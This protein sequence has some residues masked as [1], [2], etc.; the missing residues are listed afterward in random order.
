MR[1]RTLVTIGKPIEED[2][3]HICISNELERF[4]I[5]CQHVEWSTPCYGKELHTDKIKELIS[6]LQ[7]TLKEKEE[8]E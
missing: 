3:F 2:T 7:N 8:N 4:V 6:F 5:P 1:T